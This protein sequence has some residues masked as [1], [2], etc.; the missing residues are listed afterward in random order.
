V[1]VLK[2]HQQSRHQLVLRSPKSGELF[3]GELKSNL[4]K[5]APNHHLEDVAIL[6]CLGPTSAIG[7]LNHRLVAV[8][9]SESRQLAPMAIHFEETDVPAFSESERHKHAMHGR[10][11]GEIKAK[12]RGLLWKAQ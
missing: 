4:A 11:L 12:V 9:E 3:R 2:V 7:E 10:I 5:G 8:E 1:S 6:K